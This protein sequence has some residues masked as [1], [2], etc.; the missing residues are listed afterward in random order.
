MRKEWGRDSGNIVSNVHG[1]DG[2]LL[3]LNVTRDYCEYRALSYV[4]T[5]WRDVAEYVRR[6]QCGSF[7]GSN[8]VVDV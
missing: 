7:T 5:W 1:R 6:G 4:H 3:V 8:K 2:T